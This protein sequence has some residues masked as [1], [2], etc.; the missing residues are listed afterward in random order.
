M[1]PIWPGDA[2]LVAA[3]L[4][5]EAHAV[6]ALVDQY[7]A[8]IHRVASR[9]LADARDA[10]EVTQDVLMTIA[11][12]IGT[13][14]GEAALSSWIYRVTANAAY[15]RLRSR[16]SRHEAALEPLLP[17]F[18]DGGRHVARVQDWSRELD[19]PA[20][21]GELRSALERGIGELPEEYRAVLVLRDV[22]GLTNEDVAESLGLTV[23]AVKSRLHRA[24]LALRQRLAPLFPGR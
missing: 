9:L 2:A 19:D 24:R 14:K 6:E 8:W 1:T 12:K 23:A 20:V 4:R 13:F 21:A 15:E 7:G 10:E 18:D 22:E 16:R 17:V 11:Q 5:G 3:L